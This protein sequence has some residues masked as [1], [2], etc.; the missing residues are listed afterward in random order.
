MNILGID[1][2]ISRLGWG[3][4]DLDDKDNISWIDGGCVTTSSKLE[5]SLRYWEIYSFLNKIIKKYSIKLL[6]L[7]KVFFAKNVKNAIITGESRGVVLTLAGKFDVPV[8]EYAPN[9]VKQLVTGYGNASKEQVQ[10]VVKMVLNL[11]FIPQPDD[12]AD[13]LAIAYIVAR[14]Y[15][16]E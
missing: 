15:N 1:P 9:E 13:A 10:T 5:Y 2:G 6:G 16:R 3:V 8:V 11:D 4:V 12:H 14:G 7:E